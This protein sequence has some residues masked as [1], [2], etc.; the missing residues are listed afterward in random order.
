M[1]ISCPF[2]G[3]RD[4][5]EFTY[6]GDGTVKRPPLESGDRLAFEAYVYDRENPAGDHVE[7]WQ[8]TGGCRS[9]VRVERNTLTHEIGSCT[10]LG[11]WASQD[12]GEA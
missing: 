8:H 9:H 11:L 7:I 5:G 10:A 12:G 2:C 6:C 1:I 3:E 4:A